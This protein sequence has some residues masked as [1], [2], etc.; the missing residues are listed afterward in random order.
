MTWQELVIRVTKPVVIL[1]GKL[2]LRVQKPLITGMEY[3][4]W[5]D[6]IQVGD[7]IL[8]SSNGEIGSNLINPSDIKHGSIYLGRCLDHEVRYVSEALGEGVKLTDLVSFLVSK[9]RIVVVRPKFKFDEKKVIESAM[10]RVGY[11]YDYEF[12]SGDN[13]YYCFEHIALSFIDQNDAIEFK[14]S[15]TLGYEYYSSDSFLKD[16]NLFEIIV[17]S[18]GKLC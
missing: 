8:S 5:R 14:K 6:N 13:Q 16:D 2:Y 12:E 11:E 1:L 3:Y 4:L 10:T 15:K 7:I 9:D 18:E 17:D